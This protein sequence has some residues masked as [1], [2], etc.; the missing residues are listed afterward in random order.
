MNNRI[1]L[2][3]ILNNTNSLLRNGSKTG[4][5]IISHNDLKC[6][7]NDIREGHKHQS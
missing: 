7:M 2:D 4:Q 3:S 6:L 5:V 1:N